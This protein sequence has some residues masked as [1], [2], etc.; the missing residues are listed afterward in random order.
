MSV[1]LP[2]I[3]SLS[4]AHQPYQPDIWPDSSRWLLRANGPVDHA[5]L[6]AGDRLGPNHVDV[7]VLSLVVP[8]S[9][10][11]TT[12]ATSPTTAIQ[13]GIYPVLLP[14]S[15]PTIKR[16]CV[17]IKTAM[18]PFK[19]GRI[20]CSKLRLFA[21]WKW[22]E[23]QRHLGGQKNQNCKHTSGWYRTGMDSASDSIR[24]RLAIIDGPTERPLPAN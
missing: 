9:N 1:S 10:H 19:H 18:K 4:S 24:C 23:M 3:T 2:W 22:W 16:G 14:R 5:V 15:V 6:C 13:H 12:A 21:S 8:E 11:R 7:T 20:W 17:S